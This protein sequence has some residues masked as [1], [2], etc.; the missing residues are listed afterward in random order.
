LSHQQIVIGVIP[1]SPTT[2][3]L[4]LKESHNQ[5]LFEIICGV[6]T[7]SS[8]ITSITYTK[9]IE[10][11]KSKKEKKEKEKARSSVLELIKSLNDDGW[12]YIPSPS[13]EKASAFIN[14][15]MNVHFTLMN[16]IASGYYGGIYSPISVSF[17]E[18]ENKLIKEEV[19]IWNTKQIID[20]RLKAFDLDSVVSEF[21]PKSTTKNKP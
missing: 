16:T 3:L 7:T 8:V 11:L 19:E 21:K 12:S 1:I 15:K 10:H 20:A 6:I 5:M 18:S 9:L 4:S 14:K 2:Y 17:T 13:R